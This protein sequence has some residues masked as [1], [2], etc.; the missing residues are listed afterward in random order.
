MEL[1]P[2]G[3]GG[4]SISV[5]G[6]GCNQL[7]LD[8]T[9]AG[10]RIDQRLLERAVELGINHFDSADSYT[11]GDSERVLGLFRRRNQNIFVGTKVGFLYRAKN[12]VQ[13]AVWPL[14]CGAVRRF[15]NRRRR[16]IAWERPRSIQDF[17]PEYV[18]RTVENSLRRLATECIDLMYLHSP[19]ATLTQQD[20]AFE[21]IIR[22]RE[23]GKVRF[24]GFSTRPGEPYPLDKLAHVGLQAIQLPLSPG[25]ESEAATLLPWAAANGIGT[26]INMPFAKGAALRLGERDWGTLANGSPRNLA[27]AALR[28]A[29][30]KQGVTCAIPGTT[31]FA[32]MEQNVV[33]ANSPELSDPEIGHLIEE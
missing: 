26:V 23:A 4:P 30:Q 9:A 18:T 29:L 24:L 21:T 27:Q 17:S 3:H 10:R 22:L 15:P 19:P 32:H 11:H 7:G 20:D 5:V 14:V 31:S 1:R 28:Y 2:L 13:R 33:A 12:P 8:G 6:L 16:L 25:Q